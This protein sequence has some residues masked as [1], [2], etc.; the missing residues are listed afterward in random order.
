M[1]IF[2]TLPDLARVMLFC[3]VSGAVLGVSL[4]TRP[5]AAPASVGGCSAAMASPHPMARVPGYRGEVPG[6][7]RTT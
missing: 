6:W 5:A 3:L 1:S 2:C 7:K 4:V